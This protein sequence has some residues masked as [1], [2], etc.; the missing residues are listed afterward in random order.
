VS[1]WRCRR[2]VTLWGW[3]KS[4]VFAGRSCCSMS[5][6][7]GCIWRTWLNNWA[8][9]TAVSRNRFASR[10][11]LHSLVSDH[12][13]LAVCALYL[14]KPICSQIW[15]DRITLICTSFTWLNSFAN[16]WIQ[17]SLFRLC[18]SNCM[19]ILPEVDLNLLTYDSLQ[20]CVLSSY[21][22]V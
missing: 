14:V 18:H 2:V 4:R 9:S 1:D 16:L 8:N 10:W 13:T 15:R 21:C 3:L 5:T 7:R 6:S 20:I 17:R 19:H 12:L 22:A 11:T